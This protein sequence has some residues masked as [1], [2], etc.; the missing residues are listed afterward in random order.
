MD[1]VCAVESDKVG[2]FIVF[3]CVSLCFMKLHRVS[4]TFHSK[5]TF[6]SIFTMFTLLRRIWHVCVWSVMNVMNGSEMG[7]ERWSV[8]NCR[9]VEA[10]VE[11]TECLQLSSCRGFSRVD[12]PLHRESGEGSPQGHGKAHNLEHQQSSVEDNWRFTR[13]QKFESPRWEGEVS[14]D[15]MTHHDSMSSRGVFLD[16]RTM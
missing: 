16:K 2:I 5:R 3:H 9:P 13:K 10:S 12:Q 4:M 15:G 14:F 8:Y 1:N 11:L 7:M 6:H